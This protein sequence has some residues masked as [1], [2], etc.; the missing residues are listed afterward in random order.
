MN[1]RKVLKENVNHGS[2][3]FPLCV[4]NNDLGYKEHLLDYHWHDE[5]EF[6]YLSK[7]KAIFQIDSTPVELRE[8]EAILI[9]RGEVH[10]GYSLDNSYCVYYS[11]VFSLELLYNSFQDICYSRYFSPLARGEK[12]LPQKITEKQNWEREIL[13]QIKSIISNFTTKPEGYE[14]DIKASILK[15]FSLLSAN[16]AMISLHKKQNG[17]K[18]VQTERLKRA[19]NYIKENYREK[20]CIDDIAKEVNLT[21]YHFCRIFKSLTGQTPVEYINYFRINQALRLLEDENRKIMDIAFDLGFNNL[22]YFVKKFKEY[23]NCT[24]SEYRKMKKD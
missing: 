12:K 7:G 8:N 24:P 13:S 3:A 1:N 22:S 2:V 19:L 17:V 4:Y 20:I 16:N 15:I 5:I 11:I 14:M 6:L 23:K 10:S 21:R 9:N 18:Q